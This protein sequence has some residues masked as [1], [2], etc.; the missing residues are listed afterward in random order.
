MT[1]LDGSVP[2]KYGIR[3]NMDEKYKV[4]KKELSQLTSIPVD[5]ILFVEIMGPIVKVIYFY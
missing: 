5:Q 2:I 1:R 3:L 4:L